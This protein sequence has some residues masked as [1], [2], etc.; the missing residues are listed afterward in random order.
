[1]DCHKDSE[2]NT[3]CWEKFANQYV[4]E[5]YGNG[6]G[7]KI[8]GLFQIEETKARVE[9]SSWSKVEGQWLMH[10]QWESRAWR[11]WHCTPK[12]IDGTER[13]L[14][15]TPYEV[16]LVQSNV[17]FD[18]YRLHVTPA[19]GTEVGSTNTYNNVGHYT[20]AL[21]LCAS[22][23]GLGYYLSERR[24]KLTQYYEHL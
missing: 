10:P 19:A 12:K 8:N 23:F 22:A 21:A 13:T 3:L 2:G 24:T 16:P 11:A 15:N 5:C 18:T 7:T 20:I 1:M 17:K 14:Q 9:S 6:K 4:D